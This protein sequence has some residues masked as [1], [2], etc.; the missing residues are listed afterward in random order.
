MV[1]VT[2]SYRAAIPNTSTGSRTVVYRSPDTALAKVICRKLL[3]MTDQSKQKHS[4]D[5]SADSS[6]KA[7]NETQA[8]GEDKGS[9]GYKQQ[10][11]KVTQ[12]DKNR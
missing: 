5:Q 9:Y 1:R 11:S 6:V 2:V 12:P 10:K 4:C 7:K 8:T 3:T